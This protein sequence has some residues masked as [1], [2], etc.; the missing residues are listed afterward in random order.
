MSCTT[1]SLEGELN[2]QRE[3]QQDYF[4]LE[5]SSRPDTSFQPKYSE[6]ALEKSDTALRGWL[7]RQRDRLS[8]TKS[9]T[10]SYPTGPSTSTGAFGASPTTLGTGA[11]QMSN[12]YNPG[13]ISYDPSVW[14]LGGGSGLSGEWPKIKTTIEEWKDQM[15]ERKDAEYTMEM[16]KKYMEQ[17]RQMEEER[18]R[19]LSKTELARIAAEELKSIRAQLDQLTAAL[20]VLVM[21]GEEDTTENAAPNAVNAAMLAAYTNTIQAT[22]KTLSK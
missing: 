12:M 4:G 8:G 15:R 21:D 17:Q 13:Y 14:A 11:A 16:L 18:R 2:P 22:T 19:R 3:S 7:R 10:T 5:N 1:P 20:A 9:V 6:A